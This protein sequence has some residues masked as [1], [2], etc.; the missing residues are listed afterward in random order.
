MPRG[1][2]LSVCRGRV[3]SVTRV[4]GAHTW[5]GKMAHTY[6]F[7]LFSFLFRFARENFPHAQVGT[8]ST[9]YIIPYLLSPDFVSQLRYLPILHAVSFCFIVSRERGRRGGKGERRITASPSLAAPLI[10]YL[11][12]TVVSSPTFELYRSNAHAKTQTHNPPLAAPPWWW[13]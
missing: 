2:V 1:G 12:I 10:F 3:G 5:K 13:W 6:L 4:H 7:F 11:S 9:F 8:F